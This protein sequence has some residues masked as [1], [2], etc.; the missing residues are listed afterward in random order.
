MELH[1]LPSMLETNSFD[2]IVH[3]HLEYYSLAVIERLIA[4]AGLE[5]VRAELNDV[6][7]G[8]IRLFIARA[9]RP[10]DH[11]RG[12]PGAAGAADPRVRAG[13]RLAGALRGVRGRTPRRCATTLAALCRRARRRG[14]DDPRLRRLHQ[15]QHDP[16]VR[17]HRLV[18]DPLRRRPQ[19]GQ[20]GLGDD[21]DRASR[22]SARRSR[23][24]CSPDYYL[25]LPWHFLDEFLEREQEFLDARRALHRA[26]ARGADRARGLTSSS[27]EGPAVLKVGLLTTLE[28]AMRDRRV[29]A[30]PGDGDAAPRRRRP[31]HVRLAQRRRAR[32]ARVR[33]GR[34]AG[35]STS[36]RGTR[37]RR[38]SSTSRRCSPP[39]STSCTSSTATSSTS[40]GG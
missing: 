11:A 26:A 25:A 38:T 10:Q 35:A 22:S 14:Q 13:A 8:S 31:A 28:H 24:P 16:P 6:N 33:G 1:Y 2:A 40:A 27:G 4:E 7:G 21:R 15:G 32:R 30:P 20:V 39:A 34:D 9:G 5:I 23:A 3:E 12:G 17:G 36:R 29:L 37:R 18:A 19:P